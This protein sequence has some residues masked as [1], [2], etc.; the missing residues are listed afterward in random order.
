MALLYYC[1]TFD[2][3]NVSVV[4]KVDS[5]VVISFSKRANPF[6]GVCLFCIF[7]RNEIYVMEIEVFEPVVL[8]SYLHPKRSYR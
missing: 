4:F 6:D 5:K 7:V 8:A 3:C 2:Y 1:P